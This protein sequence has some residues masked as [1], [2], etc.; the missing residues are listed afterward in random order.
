MF[1]RMDILNELSP[2]SRRKMNK[3]QVSLEVCL[4]L[5][6]SGC[7]MGNNA[8]DFQQDMTFPHYLMILI[9]SWRAK[10]VKPIFTYFY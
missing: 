2:L 6:V 5:E 10:T 7:A 8:L 1:F 3:K 4:S 9:F